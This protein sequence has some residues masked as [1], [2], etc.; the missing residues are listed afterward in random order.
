[1]VPNVSFHSKHY[2]NEVRWNT[3][4]CRPR[5]VGGDVEEAEWQV[6]NH[7]AVVSCVGKTTNETDSILVTVIDTMYENLSD[8]EKMIVKR[9]SSS[10]E[11][12]NNDVMVGYD[13]GCYVLGFTSCVEGAIMG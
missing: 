10:K 6:A 3:A 11:N 1:M 4:L 13:A 5:P 7:G 2:P 12:F 8:Q 9:Y